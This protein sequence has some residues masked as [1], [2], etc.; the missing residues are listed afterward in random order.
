M[1]FIFDNVVKVIIILSVL[2]LTQEN[3]FVDIFTN[4]RMG[5]KI[6]KKFLLVKIPGCMYS[7]LRCMIRD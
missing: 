4:K 7:G 5:D 3:L 6:A 2:S 1:E